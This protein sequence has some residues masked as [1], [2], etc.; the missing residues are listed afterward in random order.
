M[1]SPNFITANSIIG[2]TSAVLLANTNEILV[3]EN[4]ASSGKCLKIN[5]LNLANYGIG[6]VLTTV[7]YHNAAGLGGSAF[8]IAGNISIPSGSTM[9][10]IDKSSQYYLDENTC[11]GAVASTPSNVIATISYE[12]IS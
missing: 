3:L 2:K 4:I 8:P 1:A 10:I 12:E 6:T 5:T 11:I 9:N 7:I